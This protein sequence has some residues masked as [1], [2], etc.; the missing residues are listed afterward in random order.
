[1]G[2]AN[3]RGSFEERKAIAIKEGRIPEERRKA[4]RDARVRKADAKKAYY[5]Y[6][7]KLYDHHVKAARRMGTL[8]LRRAIL[9]F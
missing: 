7:R 5:D 2:E 1:M 4:Q 9:E 3:R 8:T 6:M